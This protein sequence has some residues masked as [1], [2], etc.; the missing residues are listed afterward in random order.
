MTHLVGLG[1]ELVPVRESAVGEGEVDR[2][3]V[4]AAAVR[5]ELQTR[6]LVARARHPPTR[7]LESHRACMH[8]DAVKQQV[9][10]P[11]CLDHRKMC[12]SVAPAES[13]RKWE[14]QERKLS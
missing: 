2:T 14:T 11:E 10:C 13:T 1:L 9:Q 3:R 8:G 6:V 12:L 5:L 4:V 7:R